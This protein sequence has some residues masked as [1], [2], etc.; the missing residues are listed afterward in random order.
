MHGDQA[1]PDARGQRLDS[2]KEIAVHLQR[3]V[4]TVQ[5]WEA[6]EGMPVHRQPHQKQ[7]SVYAFTG[8]LDAW[9]QRAFERGEDE[10][11]PAPPPRRWRG[12][13]AVAT[14]AL[15]LLVAGGMVVRWRRPEAAGPRPL[16]P[17]SP[18]GTRYFARATSE[19]GHPRVLPAAG[20]PKWLL[21]SGD[22]ATLYV[23][24]EQSVDALAMPSGAVMRHYPVGE[25]LGES[26]LAP[27]GRL[28]VLDGLQPTIYMMAP[29]AGMATA[30]HIPGAATSLALGPDGR[31]LYAAVGYTGIERVDTN[32]MAMRWYPLPPCPAGLAMA[33]DG[34]KLY[35]TFQCGG[36]GGRK[37]HDAT[38][39]FDPVQGTLQNTFAGPPMVSSSL[40]SLSPGGDVL[41]E[42]NNDACAAPQYDHVGCPS[43]PSTELFGIDVRSHRVVHSLRFRFGEGLTKFLP[44]A[45]DAVV[46]GDETAIHFLPTTLAKVEIV[47]AKISPA[48]SHDGRWLALSRQ[49]GIELYGASPPGCAPPRDG[50]VAWWPGDGSGDDVMEGQD[51]AL[52]G[53]VGFAPGHVGQAFHFAGGQITLGR[54][55]FFDPHATWEP[56]S[57]TLALWLKPDGLQPAPQAIAS[58][59]DHDRA[60][61]WWMEL[62]RDQRV[63]YCAAGMPCLASQTGFAPGAWHHVAVTDSTGSVTLFVDGRQEAAWRWSVDWQSER[64]RHAASSRMDAPRESFLLGAGPPP[65]ARFSGL[66]DEIEIY[67]GALA[68]AGLSRLVR[69]P[70][71]IAAGR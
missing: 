14:G 45:N 42:P 22:D 65:L 41:W 28:F 10:P 53:A 29:G 59:A 17:V 20:I 68:P 70:A 8:E 16:P 60:R 71:C 47:P 63:R 38:G 64:Q 36:P 3:D 49:N 34:R 4:R 21:F 56:G 37:G 54:S 46:S 35:V 7:G 27:D 32:T 58:K 44:G 26:V 55:G 43:V 23:V 51:G 5:R 1:P 61:G 19:G 11:A 66:M 9:R 52:E 30:I 18:F 25:R 67:S 69:E 31:A 33:P 24:S 62:D 15:L 39:V 57:D 48:V 12:W 13:T 50:L 2:W 6:R 40:P